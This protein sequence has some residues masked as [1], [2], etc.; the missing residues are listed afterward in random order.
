MFVCSSR[1]PQLY[2][3]SRISTHLSGPYV[4]L[5][6]SCACTAN[7]FRSAGSAGCG[8]KC[9]TRAAAGTSCVACEHSCVLSGEQ[10]VG[11]AVPWSGSQGGM[12]QA[13]IGACKGHGDEVTAPGMN[14]LAVTWLVGTNGR[15][16]CETNGDPPTAP[17]VEVNKEAMGHQAV[18]TILRVASLQPHS[19]IYRARSTK[20]PA[21]FPTPS[22]SGASLS[23]PLRAVLLDTLEPDR[24]TH[25]L[26]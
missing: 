25:L 17:G 7:S 20:P 9:P 23:L 5:C 18:E 12:R 21:G 13:G 10:Q 1:S 14:T 3:L 8:C 15:G 11:A 24:P 4:L 16:T 26:V 6:T 2:I 19:D 22:G